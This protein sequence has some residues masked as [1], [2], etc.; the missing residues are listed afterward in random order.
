MDKLINDIEEKLLSFSMNSF[1]HYDKK[2]QDRLIEIEQAWN[3]IHNKNEQLY[4]QLKENLLNRSKLL[5]HEF[6]SFSRKTSY[7]DSIINLYIDNVIPLLPDYFNENKLESLKKQVVDLQMMYNS[8]L[9]QNISTIL[10][11]QEIEELKKLVKTKESRVYALHEIIN[12]KDK[13]IMNM[14][15]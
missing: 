9:R 12:E 2:T 15:N 6:I 14:S 5:E 3:D 11:Q 8:I 1:A 13:I 4:L 10:L 7:N